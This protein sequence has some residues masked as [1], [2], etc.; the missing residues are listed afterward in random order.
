MQNVQAFS[1]LADGVYAATTEVGRPENLGAA[2]FAQCFLS[3]IVA[4]LKIPVSASNKCRKA[5]G[6]FLDMSEDGTRGRSL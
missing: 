4:L 1:K 5:R 3:E 6:R 2:L